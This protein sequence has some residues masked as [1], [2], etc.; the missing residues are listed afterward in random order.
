LTAGSNITI[1]NGNGTI[2]IAAAGGGREVL[3]AN[4]TYYVGFLPGTAGTGQITVT[5]GTPATITCTGHALAAD[6]PVIFTA[7]ASIRGGTTGSLP[8]GIVEGATYYVRTVLNANQFTVSYTLG[9]TAISTAASSTGSCFIR[10]GN[11][12]NTGLNYDASATGAL[13]TVNRAIDLVASIDLGPYNVTI[14]LCKGRYVEQINTKTFVGAG[15]VTIRGN[16]S[17]PAEVYLSPYSGVNAAL[18]PSDSQIVRSG[19]IITYAGGIAHGLQIGTPIR[20]FGF[21]S[22]AWTGIGVWNPQSTQPGTEYYVSSQNFTSTQ[23]S[24]SATS[25]LASVVTLNPLS[26]ALWIGSPG[27]LNVNVIGQYNLNG[28]SFGSN[29]YAYGLRTSLA[30]MEITNTEFGG[31]GNTGNHIWAT[32]GSFIYMIGN[33]TVSQARIN[34]S[35]STSLFAMGESSVLSMRGASF[36]LVGSLVFNNFARMTR[37]CTFIADSFSFSGPAATGQRFLIEFNSTARV[38]GLGAGPT[39]PSSLPGSSDQTQASIDSTQCSVNFST[40]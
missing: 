8:A 11:D 14:Q 38:I 3:T 18:S 34:A 35:Y 33:I 20:F 37:M 40:S 31:P 39:F 32:N 24:I 12:S 16:P 2:S 10:A 25:N 17:N 1:T 22:A 21:G 6:T 4:R 13:L 9:G 5:S 30:F 7:G 28:V 19:N 23:F 26:S 36:T 15:P 29:T 27:M